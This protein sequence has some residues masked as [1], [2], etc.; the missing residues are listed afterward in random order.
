MSSHLLSGTVTL[1]ESTMSAPPD[2]YIQVGPVKT[3]YWAEGGGDRVIVLIHG[4]SGF[5]EYWLPGISALASQYR[6]YALDLVGH[7]RSDKPPRASYRASDLAHFV[8]EF[9]V[10]LN[11]ERASLVGHSLGGAIALQFALQFPDLL[12]GLVLVD[13]AGLGKELPFLLRLTSIPRLGELLWRRPSRRALAL[14]QRMQVADPAVITD[15]WLDFVYQ[16][17]AQ[18]D[19]RLALLK[20]LRGMCNLFGQRSDFVTPI[21]TGLASI[22]CPTLV[23]WGQHDRIIPVT[24]AQVAVKGIP[25]TRLQVFAH[26]GHCPMLEQPHAFNQAMQ[27]FLSP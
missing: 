3:R 27:E 7:G 2:R 13:S 12:D 20:T 23:M 14:G 5:S 24:H 19:L 21:V 22:R 11:L 25:N 9:I 10:T 16:L 4:W 26:C 17:A 1:Q 15:E 8:K 6:V 18:P